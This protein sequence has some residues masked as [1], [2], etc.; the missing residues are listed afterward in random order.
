ML[1]PLHQSGL[2]NL[3]NRTGNGSL[4]FQGLTQ[5]E[6]PPPNGV[7]PH[8]G[9][10]ETTQKS[11]KSYSAQ[12]PCREG[13]PCSRAGEEGGIFVALSVISIF[14]ILSV[15]GGLIS[16]GVTDLRAKHQWRGHPDHDGFYIIARG[17]RVPCPYR[18]LRPTVLLTCAAGAVRVR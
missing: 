14:D 18:E 3:S 9:A 2:M 4:G 17:L 16:F 13:N 6:P 12:V 7:H 10:G 11:Y 15:V 8:F 5:G 1:I